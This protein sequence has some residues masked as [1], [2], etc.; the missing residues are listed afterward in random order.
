MIKAIIF[1]LDDTLYYELN[2]VKSGF[3]AVSEYISL[4]YQVDKDIFYQQL[5]EVLKDQGRGKIFNLALEKFALPAAEVQGM[6][7]VYRSHI[8]E[9]IELYNDARDVLHKYKTDK[10][11]KTG[12][13]TDGNS[14]V[15][16]KKI[17]T[18]DL[19]KLIDEI[20]VSDDYGV[21]KRK[22]NSFLYS[23]MLEMLNVQAEEAVYI[24]DNPV[25][26]FVTARK[27]GIKTVRIIRE[28]GMHI[29]K[30]IDQEY[31]ADH[32]IN[33]LYELDKLIVDDL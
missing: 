25:K 24:G 2:Y 32:E 7:T 31:E 26:D 14:E 27:L 21:A 3:E 12:I 23:K 10:K 17:K 33:T 18:L 15:Q 11:Y 13:I 8:P 28:K 4:R 29:T 22:P 5:L 20:L 1:D 9:G 16:W 6:V 30:R 19:L